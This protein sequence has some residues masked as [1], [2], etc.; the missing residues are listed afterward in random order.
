MG[1]RCGLP[2]SLKGKYL[3]E[4]H[5]QI[6]SLRSRNL[7]LPRPLPLLPVVLPGVLHRHLIYQ[8]HV[9]ANSVSC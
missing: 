5:R 2:G 3:S 9:I 7:Q 6:R 8:G 4:L 1:A